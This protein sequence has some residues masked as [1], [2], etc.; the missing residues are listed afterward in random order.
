MTDPGDTSAVSGAG[1]LAIPRGA[2][3]GPRLFGAEAGGDAGTKMTDPGDPPRSRVPVDSLSHAAR[4]TLGSLRRIPLRQVSARRFARCGV[5]DHRCW[6][7][8]RPADRRDHCHSHRYRGWWT[9]CG[10]RFRCRRCP[11]PRGGCRHFGP[12][13]RR[14]DR[15]RLP[16]RWHR[17]A[18]THW[19]SQAPP[20]DMRPSHSASPHW[21]TPLQTTSSNPASN[22]ERQPLHPILSCD[23]LHRHS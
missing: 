5:A 6:S 20:S 17:P 2:T 18:S 8:R 7:D 11:N 1:G 21:R 22:L 3:D 23:R 19:R 14:R 12:P 10:P 13:T 9:H 15:R 4:P 16:R